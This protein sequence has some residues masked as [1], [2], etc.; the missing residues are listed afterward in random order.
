MEKI[1]FRQLFRDYLDGKLKF[2][3]YQ[4]IC[5]FLLLV[6]LSG[7]IGWMWEFFLDETRDGFSRL[8]IEGGN[9]LP[10]INLYAYGALLVIPATR[11]IRHRPL[12]VFSV[13][14]VV[15]GIL[16]LISGILVFYVGGGTRYW[17][18]TNVWWG[19]GHIN[20]FVCPASV[21]AFGIGSMALVYLL[22]PFCLYVAKILKK[23]TL[24]VLSISLFSIIVVDDLSNL[25]LKHLGLP[26]SADF[27]LSAGWEYREDRVDNSKN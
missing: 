2:E 22:Y 5:V 8:I 13:S 23:R 27:Y 15:T 1:S 20:G 4:K 26:N 17:D 12:A 21:V 10:W 19:V 7:F 24:L 16:E 25:V 6:V 3:K 18:Y 14:A 11:K 9:F